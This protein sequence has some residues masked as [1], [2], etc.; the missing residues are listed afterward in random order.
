ML[1]DCD[2]PNRSLPRS[3]SARGNTCCVAQKCFGQKSYLPVTILPGQ[4]LNYNRRLFIL[5]KSK[6]IP[7]TF[8]PRQADF[9]NDKATKFTQQILL[10][11]IYQSSTSFIWSVYHSWIW[12]HRWQPQIIET[13]EKRRYIIP[14]HVA[15]SGTWKKLLDIWPGLN[16]EG[17]ISFED[18]VHSSTLTSTQHWCKKRAVVQNITWTVKNSVKELTFHDNYTI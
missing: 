3:P 14:A 9:E 13:N 8:W 7:L 16:T 5:N 15:P 11:T 17:P 4:S 12:H 10:M 1:K 2:T 18:S 6:D